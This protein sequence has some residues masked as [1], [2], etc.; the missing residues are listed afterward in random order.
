MKK[1][2]FLYNPFSGEKKILKFFDYIIENYQKKEFVII[3]FRISFNLNLEDAFF[4]I[5]SNY[6]H[7]LISGG[8]GTVNKVVNIMKKKKIN[9]PIAIL[10][11]GTANDFAYFLGMPKNIKKSVDIIL[12][13]QPKSIDLGLAND[14]YFVNIFSCGLFTDVSQK[15]SSEYKNMFGKLA[16]YFTGIK[17]LPKF[18]TLNLSIS[19]KDFSFQGES[20]LFFILN[21]KTAG[22]F[23]IAHDSLIDDGLLNVVIISNENLIKVIKMLPQFLLKKNFA[24]PKEI[25][26][27]KTSELCIDVLNKKYSTDID[28]EKGPNFPIQISCIKNGIKILGYKDKKEI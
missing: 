16:Y 2:K 7:I 25:I 3:P 13:S 4:D 1:V 22:S 18:K 26:N 6:D 20:I 27:F 17:E 28:G 5:D 23:E 24:Y 8:D 11:T 10:P 14:T 21:G 15:T 12:N 19:S 9:L